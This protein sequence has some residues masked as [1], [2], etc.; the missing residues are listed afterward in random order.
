MRV[1]LMGWALLTLAGLLQPSATAFTI[2]V[3]RRD[4]LI[5]PFATYDG[6]EWKNYWPAPQGGADVPISLKSVSRGWWGPLGPRETWQ[7]W[8]PDAPPQMVKV[9]QPDWASSYCHKA[10][11]LRTDYQPRFRPPPLAV[12][13]YPKD[14]LAVSPPHPVEPIEILGPDSPERD[15][16]VEAIHRRFVER[17][18]EELDKLPR[19]HAGNPRQYPEPPGEKELRASPPMVIEALYA[20]GSSPRTYFVEGAREYMRDGACAAVGLVRGMVTRDSGKFAT[21]GISVSVA[22]CDRFGATYMLPL[23]VM[24]FPTG[25]YWIAQI[26]GWSRESYNIID[27]TPGSKALE[28]SMPGGGC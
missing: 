11:G 25:V 15:D 7:I 21:E 1:F 14:G 2:G 26:S 24:S 28:R 6:K 10:V 5:V 27:I 9:R 3:L 4:A 22:A 12:N 19:A 16:I 13:P 8:M 20:Y 18:R 17:E 23:G